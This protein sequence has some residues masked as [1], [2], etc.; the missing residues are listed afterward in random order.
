MSHAR[1]LL[2]RT[3]LAE[4]VALASEWLLLRRATGALQAGVSGPQGCRTAVSSKGRQSA[5][6]RR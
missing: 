2:A 4:P 3:A 1:G 5:A 6:A